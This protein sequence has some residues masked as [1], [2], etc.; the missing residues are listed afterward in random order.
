MVWEAVEKAITQPEVL[1]AAVSGE[2]HEVQSK[3]D[4]HR[5]E[6]ERCDQLLKRLVD[7]EVTI[8]R[9]FRH[10]ELSADA[11]RRQLKEINADRLI[12]E[13]SRDLA[14]QQI[15]ASAAV[16]RSIE[17]VEE[18]I[19]DLRTRVQNASESNRQAIIAALVPDHQPF[20]IVV[21]PDGELAIRGAIPYSAGPQVV[22]GKRLSA[23]D[24]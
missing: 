5:E 3:I 24:P 6:V 22:T 2:P 21:H 23:Q 7:T 12:L 4:R 18:Q 19:D 16:V 11:W 15:E 20:G 1:R 8:T 9:T 10:G 13:E 14:R 17:D